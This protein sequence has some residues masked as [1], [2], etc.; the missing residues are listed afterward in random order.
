MCSPGLPLSAFQTSTIVAETIPY[1]SYNCHGGSSPLISIILGLANRSLFSSPQTAVTET[2]IICLPWS[3]GSGLAL[4]YSC[5]DY[6]GGHIIVLHLSHK[7]LLHS[8][9]VT[10][11]YQ[12][13]LYAHKRLTIWQ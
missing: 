9:H 11:M 7:Q 3:Y 2:L 5:N 13:R 8:H 4:F 6:H 1:H 12:Y 10:K